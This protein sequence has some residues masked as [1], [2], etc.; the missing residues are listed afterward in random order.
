MNAKTSGGLAQSFISCPQKRGRVDKDRG[1]QMCV[2]Q[3]DPQAVQTER[4]NHQ[5]YLAHMRHSHLWQKVQQCKRLGTLLQRSQ[6]QFRNDKRVNYDVPLVKMLSHFRAFRTEVINPNRR[7]CQN[8]FD[9]TRR[10]RIFFSFGMVPPRDASLRA[11]SRSM[12][13]LRAS[14]INAV[15]SA[16]PV[17]SW[18][19]R[20]R[21]SSS[22]RVVL[23]GNSW[24]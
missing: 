7:I 14:R 6:S 21:S 17:N 13:A 5:P 8:Q 18:A 9:L 3:T 15:F 12:R 10:R 22:A 23:M 19:M 11:L 20:T 2:S 16:T 1:Y 4:F 24:H